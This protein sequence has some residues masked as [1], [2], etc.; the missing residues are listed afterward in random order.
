M[1]HNIQSYK[2]LIAFHPGSY[3]EEII[4]DL[5]MSQEEFAIRLGTTPK[6]ISKLV[7]GEISVSKDLANKLFKL[8][9]VSILTWLNLQASY[10]AKVLEIEEL[11][12]QDEK[13]ICKLIDF[14]YF[15]RHGF[16][17][18]GRYTLLQKVAEL[19]KL[20]QISNLSLV[21]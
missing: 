9:G 2:D 4:E 15:K 17:P 19:R 16:V 14:E 11:Q 5:N 20:F 21:Y 6:T 10:D 18:Q 3:A 1:V 12:N 7:N 8:T 13:A